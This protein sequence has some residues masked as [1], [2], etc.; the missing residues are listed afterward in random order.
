[1]PTLPLW[2]GP[3]SLTRL[4]RWIAGATRHAGATGAILLIVGVLYRPLA[5]PWGH[6]VARFTTF[7]LQFYPWLYHSVGSSRDL[8]AEPWGF[9]ARARVG[10]A[11]LSTA[12]PPLD[13]LGV[14]KGNHG[15]Q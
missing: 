15:V 11:Q 8:W 9:R 13:A 4:S 10:T 7:T 5:W 12:L 6:P 3:E 14:G 1:V 2:N